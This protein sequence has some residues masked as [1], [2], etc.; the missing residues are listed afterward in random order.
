MVETVIGEAPLLL[1]VQNE[2]SDFMVTAP[3]GVG[4]YALWS[5]ETLKVTHAVGDD[6]YGVRAFAFGGGTK[7]IALKQASYIGAKFWWSKRS[8]RVKSFK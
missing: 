6:G 1:Q 4:V 5:E 7:L 8:I 2:G 3:G